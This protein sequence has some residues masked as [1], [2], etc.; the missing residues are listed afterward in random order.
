MLIA[1]SSATLASRVSVS[2]RLPARNCTCVLVNLSKILS[3]MRPVPGHCVVLLRL[4][5]VAA[6]RRGRE[7]LLEVV[8]G[9]DVQVQ[10]SRRAVNARHVLRT[11]ARRKVLQ[12]DDVAHVEEVVGPARPAV[13]RRAAS[14]RRLSIC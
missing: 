13:V 3:P 6:R 9:A 10:L 11:A 2:C 4:R 1:S 5:E 8:R 7:D 14:R 12:V